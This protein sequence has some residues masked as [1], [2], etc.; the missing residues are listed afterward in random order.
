MTSVSLPFPDLFPPDVVNGPD[1]WQARLQQNL[2]ALAAG[3][4]LGFVVFTGSGSPNGAITASPPALY[5]N[6]AGGAGSTLWVKES[7]SGNTGWA[8]K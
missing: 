3:S 1:S 5:L 7:G 6:R 8:G 4:S 2:D